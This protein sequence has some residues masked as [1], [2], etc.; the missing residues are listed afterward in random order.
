LQ[1]K[2]NNTIDL[3]AAVRGV[4]GQIVIFILLKKYA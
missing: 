4:E 1:S 2:Y 3:Q